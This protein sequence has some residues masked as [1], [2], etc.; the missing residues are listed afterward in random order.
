M[1]YSLILNV[2]LSS[3]AFYWQ[4]IITIKLALPKVVAPTVFNIFDYLWS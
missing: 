3:F 2:H 4:S 1:N